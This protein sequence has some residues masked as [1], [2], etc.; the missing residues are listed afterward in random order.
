MNVFA[1]RMTKI[2]EYRNSFTGLW[3]KCYFIGLYGNGGLISDEIS[4]HI[5]E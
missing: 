3:V 4:I 1:A 5:S 2:A